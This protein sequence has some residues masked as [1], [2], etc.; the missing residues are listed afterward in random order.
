M[1]FEGLNLL[2]AEPVAILW[3]IIGTAVGIVFGAV[4]GLTATMAI[5]IFLPITYGLSQVCGLTTIV[6]LYIGGVSGG[7]ISAILLNMPG[8]PSSVATCFDGRP[9]AINGQADKAIGAGI[10]FSFC[11][12]IFSIAALVFIAPKLANIAVRFAPHEYFAVTFFSISLI[13]TLSSDDLKKGFMTAILGMMLSCVGLDQVTGVPRYTFDVTAIRSGFSIL[14]VLVG[15]YA[16]REVFATAEDVD[17]LRNVK[18]DNVRMR[19]VGITFKEFI[20]QWWNFLRSAIIGLII[21]IL[22]GIGGGTSNIIAYTVAKNQSKYPEKFGTG[23]LDGVVAPETANNATIG[24]AM[25]P[26]LTLGIPGDA[27][28][29]MMLGG[30][31]VHGLSPGPL[32]FNNY[33]PFLYCIFIVMVLCS[34]AMVLLEFLGLRVFIKVLKVPKNYLLPMIIV[35]CA[36]GAFGLNSRIFDVG[37]TLLFGIIGMVLAKLNFPLPPLILGFILGDT[38]EKNFRLALIASK[39]DYYAFLSRP[40]SGML[41][42][43][44]ILFIVYSLFRVYK[45]RSNS[46]SDTF[47]N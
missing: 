29:A 10:I 37:A 22:P 11:G 8:T 28:T 16:I 24:G 32:I 34:I 20:S 19:G 17:A 47:T 31:A 5:A 9:M 21:G 43:L 7:L 15:L 27:A 1:L 33:G 36:I 25:I 6:A 13:I 42:V 30:L 46:L 40:I 12:T 18:S 39:G 35:L 38:M 14:T 41:I 44:T 45:K 4:P 26:L 2:A 23:I 3:I